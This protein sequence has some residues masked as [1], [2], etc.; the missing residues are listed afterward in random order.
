MGRIDAE[1]KQSVQLRTL[2]LHP[3]FSG[4]DEIPLKG[5]QMPQ[6][7]N[8]AVTFRYWPFVKRA[9]LQQLEYLVGTHTRS[10]YL[11]TQ[12]LPNMILNE[13]R[14]HEGVAL[15]SVNY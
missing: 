11:G 4:T 12:A 13:C 8:Q 15:L 7:K 14:S 5:F 6:I 1:C 3:E 10:V 9:G 2:G